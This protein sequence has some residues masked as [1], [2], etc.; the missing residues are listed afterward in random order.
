[1]LPEKVLEL[2]YLF[3]V[4]EEKLVLSAFFGQ[5]VSAME[6]PVQL[7]VLDIFQIDVFML[8]FGPAF[9]VDLQAVLGKMVMLLI[10]PD[11]LNQV[12]YQD[13][14]PDKQEG[15]EQSRKELVSR[16]EV[17]K[18][19]DQNCQQKKE[20]DLQLH[21]KD[22]LFRKFPVQF[23]FDHFGLTSFFLNNVFI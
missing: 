22:F 6:K 10:I 4:V 12:R 5:E 16:A 7:M 11:F 8:E 1:M 2:F 13:I 20:P 23:C 17:S 15:E 19:E 14:N 9:S 18:D 3:P 21:E